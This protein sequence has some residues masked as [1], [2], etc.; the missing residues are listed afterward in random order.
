[1]PASLL[2]R[3]SLPTIILSAVFCS[4]AAA[5][6]EEIASR[7]EAP[8]GDQLEHEIAGFAKI[9]CSA[10]FI[11]GRN[12]DRAWREDGFF[13]APA[14]ARDKVKRAVIDSQ[15]LAVRLTMSN[16]VTRSARLI[17]D[18]GCVTLPRGTDKVSFTPVPVTPSLPDAQTQDWPMGD[19]L[20]DLPLPTEIDRSK[21]E[22][23]VAAAFENPQSALTAA[24]AVVYRGQIIAERYEEGIDHTTRLAGWSM[25]KS[26]TATL[27]GRLVAQGAYDVWQA[28]P[29]D[30]WQ[31][32]S[33][34]RRNIRIADLLHM[35][36]GLRCPAP[37][38]PD[39]P[40]GYPDHLYVYTGAVDAFRWS[41]TRPAQWPPNTV[42]RYRNCDPLSVGYLIRKAVEARGEDYL[43]WPQRHLFDKL[44]IRRM[45]LETDVVG[46]FLLNGYELGSARDWLRL[47]MLY[48]QGGVWN[49]ERLLPEGWTDFARTAAPM[50]AGRYGAFFWL[51]GASPWPIPKDAYF[52]AGSGG[53][54]TFIIPTHD[55]VVV[56]MG[57]DLGEA[58]GNRNLFKALSLLMEAIPHVRPAWSPPA[59]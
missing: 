21:L 9:L 38:D 19:R 25:G 36:S 6:P 5:D 7:W 13:T 59:P 2:R 3:L 56:R 40:P 35:S 10:I 15:G 50:S 52:M 27:M 33:D 31:D 22:E 30:E 39:P 16:G 55:M 32:A 28:A 58:A 11:T 17:G 8:P 42:W 45:V 12:P 18:Q 23:A 41:I 57:H 54:H 53:Q 4:I 47:G 48:L 29:I 20:P 51:A 1:M 26:I 34:P 37:Q 49:G 43:T 24:F 14:T 46:N 44:G